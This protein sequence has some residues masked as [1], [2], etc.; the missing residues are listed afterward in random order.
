MSIDADMRAGVLD[1]NQARDKRLLL[2]RESELYGSMDGAMKFV[3]GDAI[4]GI[5]ITLINIIGGLIIGVAQHGM[6]AGNAAKVYSLLS[7][8]DG[9]VSQ[10]PAILIAVCAGIVTT[11][12]SSSEKDTN[13]RK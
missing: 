12:V 2:T 10:I 9:L 3:K 7:I 4:A 5:V 8:G 11:R 1:A 13:F 6:T